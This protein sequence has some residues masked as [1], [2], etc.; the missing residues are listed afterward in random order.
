MADISP[1]V[2]AIFRNPEL[3]DKLFLFLDN[4]APLDPLL[5]NYV[6]R[7]IAFLLEKNHKDVSLPPFFFFFQLP[8]AHVKLL[9]AGAHLDEKTSR[10]NQQILGSHGQCL[11]HGFIT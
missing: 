7:L 10:Y 9:T 3:I 11:R 4:K 5:S 6:G 1:I 8:D 2:D